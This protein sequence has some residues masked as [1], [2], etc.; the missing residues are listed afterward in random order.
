MAVK[1][2]QTIVFKASAFVID[3]NEKFKSNTTRTKHAKKI[4]DER[5]SLVNVSDITWCR[6]F[7]CPF[8]RDISRGSPRSDD[9]R[10]DKPIGNRGRGEPANRKRFYNII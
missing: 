5:K 2:E 9:E 7:Q 3:C 8:L 1:I 4:I 6:V 10:C